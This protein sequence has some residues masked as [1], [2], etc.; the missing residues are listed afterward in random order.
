[1]K[2]SQREGVA[3][4]RKKQEKVLKRAIGNEIKKRENERKECPREREKREI[5]NE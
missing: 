4:V 5:G 3:R 2:K 1:M